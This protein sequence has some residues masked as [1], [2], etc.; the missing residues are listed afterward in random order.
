MNVTITVIL[1]LPYIDFNTIHTFSVNF[2]CECAKVYMPYMYQT[3]VQSYIL[4]VIRI[5]LSFKQT[6]LMKA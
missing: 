6:M 4:I 5:K 1:N 2:T 3:D